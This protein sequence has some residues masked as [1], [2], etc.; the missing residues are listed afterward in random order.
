[1]IRSVATP[2][3]G[4]DA[5]RFF[6]WGYVTNKVYTR[7]YATVDGLENCIRFIINTEE[8]L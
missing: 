3:T 6:L 1:M 8:L 7:R 4:F 5:F 2:L